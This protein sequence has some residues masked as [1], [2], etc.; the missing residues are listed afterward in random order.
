ML[1]QAESVL[2]GQVTLRVAL[3]GQPNVGKST[4]FNWLTGLNQHVGNWPG[5]TIEQKTGFCHCDGAVIHLVDLPGTYSLTANSLEEII[6]RDYIIQERPDVVVVIVNAA[7]LERNLYLVAELLS[8]PSR[9][10][11]GLNMVD[12]AAEEGM[13]VEPQV[14][15]AAL[16]VPVVPMVATKNQGVRTLIETACRL[17]RNELPYRPNVPQI[18]DDHRRVL[19][20]IRALIADMVP[21]PYPSDWVALKL[22]EG[23]PE[24]T[25]M[26]HERLALAGRWDQVHDILKAHE[27]AVLAVASGRYAWVERMVRAAVR[28]PRA[29]QITFT[30]RLDRWATHPLW[31]LGLL[32]AILG[33]VYWLTFT[34]G[35]PL[36]G[37]LEQYVVGGL[38]QLAS[39]WLTNGP[40]W[41]QGLVVNGVIGGAGTVIT[42]LP[43][44]MIFFAMLALLEDIGYMARAAYVMD[45]FMHLVGLHGKS[46]LPLFLGFGCNVPAVIGTRIIDSQ[47]ARLLTIL[48]A[49][50]VPCAG[51]MTVVAFIT[52]LFFGRMAT[53]VAWGIVTTTLLLLAVLGVLINR[54]V[55]GGERVAFIME[56]PLYHRPNRRTIFLQVWQNSLE[57]LKKAGSLILAMSVVIWVLSTLPHGEMETS[58][59]A[60]V[61]KALAPVGALMGLD[62][63]LVVAL[64]TSFVAKENSIATMGILLGAGQGAVGLQE[65]LTQILTPAAALAFLVVQ[66]LFIPCVATVAAIRQETRSWKWTAFSIGL[67]GTVSVAA[68]IGVYQVMRIV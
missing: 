11:V 48:L 23:D 31:G 51:R 25:A 63:R 33:I 39:R 64:L 67:L 12:V 57:F 65:A 21:E 16:G 66:T 22:L 13:A 1:S 60:Q 46:F 32:A 26:M 30:E 59:L 54:W 62:W 35:A 24:I 27:D 47:R 44:L 45:R 55:L 6:A 15:E 52:P 4:V 28:R 50:L 18:R 40:A 3:A 10:V 41:L 8:L 42:F 29:G 53:L 19:A 14:L 7:S 61:G 37:W 2:N 5:K 36:Q 20:E 43:I 38:A 56:L 49:P 9:V 58:Y 17:A 34:V 68:G